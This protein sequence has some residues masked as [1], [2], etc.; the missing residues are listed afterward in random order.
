[1]FT[2]P[3]IK[4]ETRQQLRCNAS[5]EHF[6]L[7]SPDK[8]PKTKEKNIINSI[9]PFIVYIYIAQSAFYTEYS[10]YFVIRDRG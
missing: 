6:I 7:F 2:S 5:T 4:S 9:V 1:M 10:S 8:V 3:V